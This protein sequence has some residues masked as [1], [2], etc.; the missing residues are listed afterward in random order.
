MRS[1]CRIRE[2]LPSLSSVY[3]ALTE[4][5][6]QSG[7]RACHVCNLLSIEEKVTNL[8]R[9]A[10]GVMNANNSGITLAL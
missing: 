7:C 9:T 2:E 10:T 6:Q 5:S 4:S 8:E 1:I 3:Q